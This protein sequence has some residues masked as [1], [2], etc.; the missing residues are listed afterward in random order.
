M[1]TG[2][3]A[4]GLTEANSSAWNSVL[5]VPFLSFVRRPKHPSTKASCNKLIHIRYAP[6]DAALL[7]FLP[8]HL[9]H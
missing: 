7:K 5:L 8:L 1:Y 3:A 4:P 9:H 6:R 2:T